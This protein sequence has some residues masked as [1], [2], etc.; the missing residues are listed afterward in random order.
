MFF[1]EK[2]RTGRY[3]FLCETVA[4]EETEEK[5]FETDFFAVFGSTFCH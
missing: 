1:S 4:V 2:R 5:S 3:P